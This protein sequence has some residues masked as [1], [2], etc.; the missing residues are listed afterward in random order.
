MRQ[1]LKEGRRK[2]VLGVWSSSSQIW[3]A[4]Y[5]KWNVKLDGQTGMCQWSTTTFETWVCCP[6]HAGMKEMTKQCWGAWDTTCG[7]KAK[8][9]TPLIACRREAW[10]EET[11]D[12]LPWKGERGP[13]SV[14]RTL[15]L[16]QTVSVFTFLITLSRNAICTL[17]M[18]S[19]CAVN[20]SRNVTCSTNRTRF[21]DFPNICRHL[22]SIPERW[23]WTT[24]CGDSN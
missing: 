16:I 14:R 20:W 12:D 5:K 17:V 3:R 10:K 19:S 21:Y 18:R 9:I 4:C 11:L 6:G 24:H 1:W 15:E 22:A 13:S 2:P 7:H 23:K 8:D